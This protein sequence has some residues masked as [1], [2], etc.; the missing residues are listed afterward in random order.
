MPS[1]PI[2]FALL[3]G[4]FTLFACYRLY[5]ARKQAK[6]KSLRGLSA[7]THI[8]DIIKLTQQHRGLYAGRLNGQNVSQANL[9]TI[10]T[11]ID[12]HYDQLI[13]S[14]DKAL[15]R[16][17]RKSH[18]MWGAL[19]INPTQDVN[20][21][22]H[23]HSS[24]IQRLLDCLWDIADEY[25]LTSHTDQ[26]IQNL[27][28]DLVRTLP[29]LTEAIGQV[30]A[31]TL[32]VTNTKYCS[33]DKKLLLLFTLGKIQRDLSQV[34]PKLQKQSYDNLVAFI[35]EI[36]KSVE[37]QALSNR[38]PDSFFTEASSHIDIIFNNI[39]SG[40][41]ELKAQVLLEPKHRKRI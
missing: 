19:L 33:A 6:A 35:E 15:K 2:L 5:L 7:L 10:R 30:R 40:L 14:P 31:I 41:K 8:I 27:A 36:T 12:R 29:K 4:L 3:I 1:S 11:Q 13:N 18:Q 9:N 22:F 28:N 37:D 23:L 32:Q 24:L 34:K 38:N 21:S 26:N 39:Q 20:K 25:A 16:L 17:I